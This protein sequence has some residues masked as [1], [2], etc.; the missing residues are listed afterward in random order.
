MD[1]ALAILLLPA[2]LEDVGFA[3]H[4]RGLLEIPRVIALE[5]SRRRTPKFMRDG[6]AARQATRISLP[7]TL[8]VV[9]LYDPAQYPLARALCAVHGEAELWYFA[10]TLE[11]DAAAGDREAEEVR[12]FDTAAR[13]RADRTIEV[14]DGAPV[15]DQPLR[16]R[17]RELD[18]ISS[19]AFIPAA[20]FQRSFRRAKRQRG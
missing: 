18:V 13:A 7:G 12:E 19:R 4:A 14:M 5:P 2:L 17:L 16:V 11:L 15:E 1:E 6:V 10:P 3:A 20:Q 8:R 9:V